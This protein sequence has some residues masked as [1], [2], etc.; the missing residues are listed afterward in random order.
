MKLLKDSVPFSIFIRAENPAIP[1]VGPVGFNQYS[2]FCTSLLFV[3]SS[4]RGIGQR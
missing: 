3:S 4:M 2:G 1:P